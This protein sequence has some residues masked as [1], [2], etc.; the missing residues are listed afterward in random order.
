MTALG[1]RHSCEATRAAVNARKRG[2]GD[3]EKIKRRNRSVG[4]CKAGLVPLFRNAL[5]LPQFV[6]C[7]TR[8]DRSGEVAEKIPHLP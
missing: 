1:S 6:C 3:T 5:G 7:Y 2:Q 8:R 4:K